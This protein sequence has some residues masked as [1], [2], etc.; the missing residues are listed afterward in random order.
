M[1]RKLISLLLLAALAVTLFSGCKK[2]EK[3]DLNIVCT[4]FPLYDWTRVILGDRLEDT[5]LTLLLDSG[6]DLH[7]YN[8]SMADKGRIIEA[9]LFVYIGGESDEQWV[10]GFLADKKTGEALNILEA[11]GEAAKDEEAVEA[12]DEHVWLSLRNA[13]LCCRAICDSLCKADP[14]HAE[15]YKANLTAYEEKLDALDRSYTEAVDG[16]KNK[17]IIVADRFPFRYLCDDYSIKAYAA[18]NGC[19]TETV[20]SQTVTD[21]LARKLIETGLK[22][23][24]VTEASDKKTANTVIETRNKLANDSAGIGIGSLNSI[25][26]KGK[27][28]VADGATYLKLM[29]DNL[30]ALKTALN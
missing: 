11:L 16:A 17:T 8:G 27:K 5:E 10:P 25:Q 7:S 29:E 4:V 19:S 15:A 13:K 18:F 2:A 6:A 1:K 20:A 12:K 3:K 30:T 24:I 28:E 21:T 22:T 26:S 9:D 23:L 14:D